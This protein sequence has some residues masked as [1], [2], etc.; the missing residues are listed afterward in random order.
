[1]NAVFSISRPPLP[2]PEFPLRPHKNGCWF[3]SVWNPRTKRSEQ[4]YFGSWTEDPKGQHAL[5]D[6][7]LGWLARRENIKAG[8]DNVRIEPPSS[9]ITLGEL[10][11]RFLS[12]K[13]AKTRAGELAQITLGD[14]LPQGN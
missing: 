12:H 6:P 1:M 11:S 13:L 4:F 3:R 10:M 14:Y 7:V 2:Y 8:V 5:S 9:A